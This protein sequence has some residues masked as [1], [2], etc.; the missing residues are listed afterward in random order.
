MKGYLLVVEPKL[1]TY[2]NLGDN[3]LVT[4]KGPIGTW[5]PCQNS[6]YYMSK[7]DTS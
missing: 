1:V 5:S 3:L 2:W 6:W 4:F 7:K